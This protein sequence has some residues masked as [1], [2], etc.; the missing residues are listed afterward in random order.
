[1]EGLAAIVSGGQGASSAS[2]REAQGRAHA[3]MASVDQAAK[4]RWMSW[5][6]TSRAG[7]RQEPEASLSKAACVEMRA[8]G[9]VVLELDSSDRPRTEGLTTKLCAASAL[10]HAAHGDLTARRSTPAR[11]AVS[12]SMGTVQT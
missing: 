10:R 9:L 6:R 1:M 11:S 7:W 12:L 5:R 3:G 8:A 4:V 2:K